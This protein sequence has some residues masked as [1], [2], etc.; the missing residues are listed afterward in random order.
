MAAGVLPLEETYRV[1]DFD[2][3][4]LLL[5][6]MIVVASLRLSGFFGLANAWVVR[7]THRPIVLLAAIVAV[8]GVFSAFLVNDT[9]C[10]FQVNTRLDAGQNQAV[11]LVRF[12]VNVRRF[13]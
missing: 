1:I 9:I 3:I 10:Q 2:T 4:T 5:G 8:S 6:M 11:S 7:R 13:S 12:R